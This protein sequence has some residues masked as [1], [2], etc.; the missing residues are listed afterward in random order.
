VLKL[1]G[2]PDHP[3]TLGLTCPR[4]AKDH[5]RLYENRIKAPALR[6]GGQLVRTDWETAL[7]I[8]AEKLDETLGKHGPEA[9][10]YLDFAGNTGLLS[11]AFP[12]RLWNAL[13]ATQTDHALCS[14]SGHA[15]IGLHY[16]DSYGLAPEEALS[17]E[18]VVFWGFNA[19]ASS[20]HLWA[21]ARKALRERGTR[22]VA[23]DPRETRTARGADLWIQPRP[24][25]DVT[26]AYGLINCLTQNG[27]ADP[28]F[29]REWTQ[30]FES[31]MDE[32]AKYSPDRVESVAGVPW[33][34]VEE[35]A[36]D[37]GHRKPSA[38]MIGIGLQK[39]D[40]G[41]DQARVV[42]FIPA[43]LGQHRGFFYSNAHGF[44][45][46]EELISGR[47]LGAKDARIVSQVALADSV[48][49]GHFK[50]I[51][52]SCMNPAVTLP[53]QHAL[54]EGLS[55]ADVFVAVHDTHWTK[56]AEYADLVLPAPTYLEKEDLV[57]PWS[58]DRVRLS[59]QVV[60]PVNNSRSEA[61]VMAELARRLRLAE[62]WLFED[63]WVS[64][65]AALE[66]ALEDGSVESLRAGA[67]LKLRIKPN[68]SYPTPSGKVE[69]YSSTAAALGFTPLPTQAPLN[70][71]DGEFVLLTSA[72]PRYTATQFQEAYGAIP[73][74]VVINTQ[75]AEGLGIREGDVVTLSNGFGELT[76]H[77][78]ISDAVPDG[79]VWSPRLLEGLAGEPQN[80]LMSGQPQ[81]IGGGPRFNS[82]TMRIA[83]V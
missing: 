67:A 16:G 43:L 9:I 81:E 83:K 55:R 19:A 20:P 79:V 14:A 46:D 13:G 44:S 82:T 34:Q 49:R 18:L 68:D 42:S 64:V 5:Q 31:L 60:R 45:V 47:G 21:L 56:T 71:P 26:L 11:G 22:I 65:E 70:T 53:N 41:A 3:M 32:A 69:F 36:E 30:G 76:V 40:Q 25:S 7:S 73:A 72:S 23:I 27:Y 39:C 29:L 8:L 6:Q 28:A 75:D 52:V 74:L 62:D 63:P 58:Q 66:G 10:L 12:T 77:A 35:L 17:C 80:C 51:Y 57:I 1:R 24:G 15:A 2:D 33:D 50:V 54:R 38:T 59:P 61:W 37:F 78:T 48:G 4:A